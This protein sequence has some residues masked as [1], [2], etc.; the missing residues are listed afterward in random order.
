MRQVAV[1]MGD[2]LQYILKQGVM[3]NSMCSRKL[4][5]YVLVV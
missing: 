1:D 4:V 3:L 2:S 5:K